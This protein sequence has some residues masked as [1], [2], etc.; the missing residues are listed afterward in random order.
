MVEL[1]G[2]KQADPERR[3]AA[4]ER[5]GQ[6]R[7]AGELTAAHVRLAASGLGVRERTVWRWLRLATGQPDGPAG[8]VAYQLSEADR[9]AYAR[10]RG[11]IAAVHRARSA[12]LASPAAPEVL[13]A[14]VPVSASLRD[15]WRGAPPVAIRTLQKAFRRELTAAEVAAWAQGE[16]GHRAAGV[17]LTRPPGHRNQTWEMDHK[18]LPILVIGVLA[19]QPQDQYL[20]V[21]ASRRPAGPAAHRP[22]GPAAADDIAMPAQDRL[23][24]D[25]QAQPLAP[26]FR[27]HGEQGREQCPVCPVQVRATRLPPL[28]D[29]EL[30]A[31]DQDLCGP[32]RFLAPGQPQPG[33]HPRDQEED[34]SQAHDR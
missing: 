31:Q 4:V 24:G 14:G 25:Q 2:G 23:R 17:Y 20:D 9:E 27:Y 18:Q 5:L 34:E 16:E 21:P 7:E 11:N 33:G 13:A 28:Q 12:V 29:G 32:P 3:R 19:S 10:Y 15:G 6:L 1:F 8:R 30:V 26:R 22:G